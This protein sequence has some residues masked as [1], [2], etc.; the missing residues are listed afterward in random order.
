MSSKPKKIKTLLSEL[1]DIKEASVPKNRALT[2][3]EKKYIEC[4]SES[5]EIEHRDFFRTELSTLSE[6]VQELEDIEN[7]QLEQE[8]IEDFRKERE[9]DS[10][11]ND[12]V[13]ISEKFSTKNGRRLVDQTK[14]EPS[15]S[16]INY[17]EIMIIDAGVYAWVPSGR[18]ISLTDEFREHPVGDYIEKIDNELFSLSCWYEDHSRRS[19]SESEFPWDLLHERG[20]QFTNELKG[21]L[22]EMKIKYLPPFDDPS[23]D[24]EITHIPNN[25]FKKHS[26]WKHKLTF[27]SA[28][29]R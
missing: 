16:N 14:E 12:T 6:E 2:S 4:R 18:Y 22:P 25:Y 10:Q 28:T 3:W 8:A 15:W 24:P 23:R 1:L 26:L 13:K 17:I 20:L 29:A 19:Y 9:H 21:L 11:C 7:E 5:W 27:G